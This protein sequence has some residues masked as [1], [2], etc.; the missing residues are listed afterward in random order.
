MLSAIR[1][2]PRAAIAVFALM[3]AFL[4]GAII[5]VFQLFDFGRFSAP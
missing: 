5:I 1:N 3:T 4:V 2:W